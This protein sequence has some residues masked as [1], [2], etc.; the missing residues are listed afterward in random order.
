MKNPDPCKTGD[1]GDVRTVTLGGVESLTAATAVAHIAHPD[2]DT[3]TLD[4]TITDT[5]ARTVDVA[6]GTAVDDWL[7]A[8]PALGFW[9]IEVEVT[10]G[11][12]SVLTF[13]NDHDDI[14]EVVDTLN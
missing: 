11:D 7:P 3:A 4:A 14:L 1:I 10:F 8:G 5:A 13:P 6:L 2:G 9:S 12:G